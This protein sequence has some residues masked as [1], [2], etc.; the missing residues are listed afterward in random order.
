MDDLKLP[1]AKGALILEL[2]SGS[3]ELYGLELV[4][5]SDG[6]LTRGGIYVHL[7]RLEDRGFVSS[8]T[9][10]DKRASGMPRRLYQITGLGQRALRA[11]QSAEAVMSSQMLPSGA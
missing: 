5:A 7:D 4:A 9:V 1:S 11:R 8:R 10:K 6:G 2:L 3:R